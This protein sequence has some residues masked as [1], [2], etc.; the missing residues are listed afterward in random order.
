MGQ[1]GQT[2]SKA[3]VIEE[4]MRGG[5]SLRSLSR[6]YGI[7][8]S[9]LHRWMTVHEE[10]RQ[11]ERPARAKAVPEDVRKLQRELAEA[12]LETQ[13][14]KTMIDIAEKDLGIQIRKKRGAK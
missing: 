1:M 14:Y 8:R 12:R 7:S 9:T 11:V 10:D 5:V 2:K 3:E 4:Y 6:K 13:I